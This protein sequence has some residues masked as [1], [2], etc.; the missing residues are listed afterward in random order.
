MGN[1]ELSPSIDEY[2]SRLGDKIADADAFRT[3]LASYIGG[4]AGAPGKE[5]ELEEI[6]KAFIEFEESIA[7]CRQV[8]DSTTVSRA[9]ILEATRLIIN[10]TASLSDWKKLKGWSKIQG[11]AKILTFRKKEQA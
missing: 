2:K 6:K 5:S 9:D 11:Q 3:L 7:I 1:F 4:L 10:M 8:F